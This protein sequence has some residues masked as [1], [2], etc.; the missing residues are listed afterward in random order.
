MRGKK[1]LSSF[2]EEFLVAA[3]KKERRPGCS[4]CQRVLSAGYFQSKG[5]RRTNTSCTLL[6]KQPACAQPPTTP[7]T[8][9][10]LH[11]GPARK[12]SGLKPPFK[13]N[14]YHARGIGD[15]MGL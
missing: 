13:I 15:K 1:F 9:T 6:Q 4:M 11:S 5:K 2:Q 12:A 10:R 7:T 8:N 3:E 14:I